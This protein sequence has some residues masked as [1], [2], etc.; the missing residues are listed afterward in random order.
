[1]KSWLSP[2]QM[3]FWDDNGYV[4][5]KS[6][7]AGERKATLRRWVEELE[8]LPETPGKWMK[9]FEKGLAGERLLCRVED[10]IPYHAGLREL[11]RGEEVVGMVSQLMGEPVVLFKEK[12]NYKLPGGKGFEPHQD[13]PAYITFNQK[14][15]ITFMISVD[16]TTIENGCLEVVR[17]WHKRG[18]LAQKQDGSLA[19]EVV[20][21]LRWEPVTTEPGDVI[22][23]DSYIPHRSGPNT[24]NRPRRVY[25]V[26]YNRASEGD[27][28]DDYYRDKREKY[29][30]EI[31][32]IPGKDYSAGAALYNLANPIDK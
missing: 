31:E 13:A 15:H 20:D 21:S 19:R 16:P 26:T 29:P 30:P 2:E 25:Y 27:R 17:G 9:Y 18:T 5:V 4:L 8:A 6:H 1:M 11:L 24:T 7:Y 10:F 23:F 12:I 22:L 32:R 28:R 14:Y 3:R